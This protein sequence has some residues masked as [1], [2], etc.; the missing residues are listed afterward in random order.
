MVFGAQPAPRFSVRPPGRSASPRRHVRHGSGL[1]DVVPT[2]QARV[3]SKVLSERSG[4]HTSDRNQERAGI[5]GAAGAADAAGA[6]GAVVEFLIRRQSDNL[7]GDGEVILPGDLPFEAGSRL[8]GRTDRCGTSHCESE[9][10][11]MPLQMFRSSGRGSRG[12][13]QQQRPGCSPLAASAGHLLIPDGRPPSVQCLGGGISLLPV[14]IRRRP[15]RVVPETET[16]Q[17]NPR[18]GARC[19]RGRL[20]SSQQHSTIQMYSIAHARPPISPLLTFLIQERCR[21]VLWGDN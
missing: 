13:P 12:R 9:R 2:R 20:I 11:R 8:P 15:R 4:G 6:A 17:G 16:A 10:V 19:G 3:S 1:P 5:A 21:L 7:V 14:L 18:P